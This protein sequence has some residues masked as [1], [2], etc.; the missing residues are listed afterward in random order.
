MVTS[1]EDI[2]D[3]DHPTPD[4]SKTSRKKVFMNWV[5]TASS[6]FISWFCF[7]FYSLN[8]PKE[9]EEVVNIKVKV[10]PN[11][12]QTTNQQSILIHFILYL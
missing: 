5:S 6:N 7:V 2:D 3:D 8:L 4:G 12:E 9:E 11:F 1:S 10:R